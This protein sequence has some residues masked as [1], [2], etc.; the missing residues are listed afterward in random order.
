M[1][2]VELDDVPRE[3]VRGVDLRRPRLDPLARENPHELEDLSLLVAQ[4]TIRSVDRGLAPVPHTSRRT[5]HISP[6][7]TS[8]LAAPMIDGHQVRGPGCSLAE[9][10]EAPLRLGG[11]TTRPQRR[12]ALHLLPLELRIDPVERRSARPARRRGR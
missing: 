7:V 6:I 2:P 10:G 5:S 3:L 9:L 4:P 8:A 12:D 11:V 1:L